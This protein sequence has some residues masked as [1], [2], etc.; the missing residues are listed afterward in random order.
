MLNSFDNLLE[1]VAE[2]FN[3][4][5]KVSSQALLDIKKERTD[6]AIVLLSNDRFKLYYFESKLHLETTYSNIAIDDDFI[7]ELEYLNMIRKQ[8]D[9]VNADNK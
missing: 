7:E 4:G 1:V 8:F 9:E 3:R 5:Y 2:I 6:I